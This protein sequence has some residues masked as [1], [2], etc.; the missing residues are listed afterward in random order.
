MNKEK[1]K[2]SIHSKS[3]LKIY[4]DVDILLKMKMFLKFQRNQSLIKLIP[5]DIHQY[6]PIE[7]VEQIRY[8]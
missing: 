2:M 6:L 7:I 5:R 1:T 8:I 3:S 4:G